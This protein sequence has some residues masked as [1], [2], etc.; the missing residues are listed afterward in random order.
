MKIAFHEQTFSSFWRDNSRYWPFL[1]NTMNIQAIHTF[2][3]QFRHRK[4]TF[5][6]LCIILMKDDFFLIEPDVFSRI[7]LFKWYRS[8]DV[9][10]QQTFEKKFSSS[11]AWRR[12]NLF[13]GTLKLNKVYEP[14]YFVLYYFWERNILHTWMIG[15]MNSLSINNIR[16][17]LLQKMVILLSISRSL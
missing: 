4:N 8:I 17:Y 3:S 12:E 13:F 1:L 9:F 11:E 2:N 6:N 10:Q 7:V 15:I 16:W 5:M 14:V